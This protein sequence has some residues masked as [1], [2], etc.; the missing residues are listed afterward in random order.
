MNSFVDLV[1]GIIK[2]LVF[3]SVV[4]GVIVF[5]GYNKIRR[6]AE[7][8]KEAWANITVSTRKKIALVNQLMEVA[9]DYQKSEQLTMLKTSEDLTVSSVQLANRQSGQ[10]LAAINGAAQRFPDLKSNQ[11]FNLLMGGIRDCELALE[12][13]RTGYNR[14]A[15]EYNVARS[16]I[17]HVFYSQLLGFNPAQYLTVEGIESPDAGI[18][19]SI[20]S[21]DGERV[22]ELLARAGN[23]VFGVAKSIAE[24][25][26][27]LTEIGATPRQQSPVGEL[28]DRGADKN[29]KSSGGL[30]TEQCQNCGHPIDASLNFCPN[31]GAA[32]SPPSVEKSCPSCG[33][34]NPPTVRFCE[35]CGK[36]LVPGKAA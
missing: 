4:F 32:S 2:F 20:V 35:E 25:G 1:W 26:R 18:Q 30:A 8:V 34:N 36:A 13:A 23:R 24:Q 11:H 7:S 17:P 22:N 15:K 14:V 21:D 33:A 28:Q 9:K 12:G 6:L 16:S 31:C 5:W 27:M 3:V 29:P 10:V 19:Q